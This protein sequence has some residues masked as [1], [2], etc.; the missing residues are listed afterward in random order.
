MPLLNALRL[1][2]RWFVHEAGLPFLIRRR[3]GFFVA[4]TAMAFALG[5]NTAVFSVFRTFLLSS[6]AIPAPER[7]LLVGPM[8]DLPGRGPVVFNDAY[9]N[10]QLLRQTQRVFSEVTCLIQG[11]SSWDQGGEVRPLQSSSVTATFFPT[12][13]VFPVL[14]RRFIEAEEG[15]SPA[16]VVVISYGLWTSTFGGDSAVVG[17]TMVLNGRPHTVIG[18][19]PAGFGQ[20]APTDIWLPFDIPAAMRTSITGAR[21]LSIYARLADDR[22]PE[23]AVA[24]MR[25]FTART[26]AAN[27]VDNRDYRYELQPIRKVLLS[28]ADDSVTLVQVGAAALLV[29][30]IVN[31]ASLLVA[32]GFDRRQE[33]AIRQALGARGSRVIR[34]LFLQSLLVVA[35]G[36]ILGVG[37]ARLALPWVRALDINPTLTSFVQRIDLDAGVLLLSASVAVLAGLL[38]GVLPAW[39]SRKA[40]LVDGLRTGSRGATLSRAALRWQQAMVFIQAAVSVVV[41]AAAALLGISFHNASRV[42]IGFEAGRLVVG[43]VALQGASYE[44]HPARAAF[45]RTLEDNLARE[46]AIAAFGLTSVLPVGDNLNG[47]RFYHDRPDGSITREPVMFHYRRISPSYLRTMSIPLLKGRL[48]DGHDDGASPGVAIVSRALVHRLWPGQNPLGKRLYRVMVTGAEP[49]PLAIVG[50][51]GDVMDAG[52][53]APAGETVYVPWARVSRAEMSVVVRPRGSGEAALVAIRHAL[54]LTDPTLAAHSMAK[55]AT[56]TEQANSLPRLQTILLLVFALVAVGLSGLGSYGVM[57][58]LIANREREYGLRLVFGATPGQLGRA[59]FLEMARMA[60]PG[61]GVGLALVLLFGDILKQ[62]VFGIEP[63]ATMVLLLVTGGMVIVVAV[64]TLP[65][66]LRA[67]RVEVQDSVRST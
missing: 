31:L 40:D 60:L 59:V 44:S 34:M 16:P 22:T 65:S 23:A 37:L 53:R 45:A 26:I 58:Q 55:L 25:D 2:L 50:V 27:S 54:Q 52:T 57:S 41:L 12:M 29:L 63:R 39:F 6:I 62:F 56:L 1:G 32:W 47:G 30:A 15:P 4:V 61:I 43:R 46:S 66:A 17:R 10:Y 36:A 49:D 64:A 51:V 21:S 48:F 38:A 33:M 67:M 9:P 35:S 8:R 11:V 24:A 42:P 7:L 13:R 20:P 28:G 3:A 14:G 19:M 5:V 18:V